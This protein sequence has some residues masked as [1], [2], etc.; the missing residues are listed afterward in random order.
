MATL[1]LYRHPLSGNAYKAELLISLL[2]LNAEI[3][4][5][6]VMKG[7]QKQADFLKKNIFG[8]IPVLEDGDVTIADSNA[9][10][11]Y[12]ASK[13]IESPFHQ[14]E[15]KIQQRLGGS[16]KNGTLR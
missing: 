7:E 14:G 3:I 2:G 9:I 13:T 12:L 11:I 15:Q 16:Q 5:V 10:L 8:Q 6:D 4:T 1:K